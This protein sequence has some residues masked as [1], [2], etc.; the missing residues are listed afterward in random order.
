MFDELDMSE[1]V[2]LERMFY[3]E[4]QKRV[5]EALK[6]MEV[7]IASIEDKETIWYECGLVRSL[8]VNGEFQ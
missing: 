5:V 7:G 2:E 8:F 1:E 3:E 6:N 4:K